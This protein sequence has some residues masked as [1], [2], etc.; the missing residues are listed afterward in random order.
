MS[1]ITVGALAAR[2]GLTVRTLHH[3]DAIGL[4]KPSG[5]T[6]AGYRLYTE[7][8]ILRLEQI[9][10]L[11]GIGLS[12]AEITGVLAGSPEQLRQVLDIH[13]DKARRRVHE[14]QTL[15]DRL[16]HMVERLRTHQLASVDEALSN[17]QIV[18]VFEKYFDSEQMDAVREHARDLGADVINEA[19]AE[20]PRLIGA[21]RHEMQQGTPPD[22]PQVLA[23]ARRWQELLDM[24]MNNRPDVGMA[25]G[26]MLSA[27]PAIRQSMGLDAEVV[28]FVARATAALRT[29]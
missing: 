15:A 12:L 29:P 16:E 25:A 8:D 20:W 11:R 3:Y 19:Q 17:I 21:V 14:Q 26:R 1:D 13:T 27:E 24:F 2:T 28:T 4:L 6:E 5:R 22:A 18:Y 9:V 10:L 23:L 7:R